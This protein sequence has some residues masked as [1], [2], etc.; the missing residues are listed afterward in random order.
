MTRPDAQETP[1]LDPRRITPASVGAPVKDDGVKVP[2]PRTLGAPQGPAADPKAIWTAEEVADP[3]QSV[4]RP[5]APTCGRCS[6]RTVRGNSQTP[7]ATGDR[8]SG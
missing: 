2:Q 1:G 3:P 6:P 7:P 5:P 4:S 8:R